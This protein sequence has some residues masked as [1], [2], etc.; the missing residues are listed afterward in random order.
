[1]EIKQPSGKGAL[2]DRQFRLHHDSRSHG[3]RARS[4]D[5]SLWRWLEH[6]AARRG[7]I[8]T[9]VQHTNRQSPAGHGKY[10]LTNN[11]RNV[12]GPDPGIDA[13]IAERP[14]NGITYRGQDSTRH[15]GD[16]AIRQLLE[17]HCATCC[18]EATSP[19]RGTSNCS[20]CAFDPRAVRNIW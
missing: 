15:I 5:Q 9:N 1:M 16:D 7:P 11:N 10:L 13:Q 20:I 8:R 12:N 6:L 18:C 17:V 2:N 4:N 3:I 19:G 14:T